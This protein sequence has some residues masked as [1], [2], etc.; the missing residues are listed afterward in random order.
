MLL[1]SSIYLSLFIYLSI[2]L[3]FSISLEVSNGKESDNMEKNWKIK[4]YW[5]LHSGLLCFSIFS[6]S[7]Y[8]LGEIWKDDKNLPL[9]IFLSFLL[10]LI[11]P[12]WLNLWW[13][14]TVPSIDNLPRWLQ[15]KPITPTTITQSNIYFPL[16]SFLVCLL[17][18]DPFLP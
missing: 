15:S 12:C 18:I 6:I 14:L 8:L 10:K 17:S 5:V 9:L 2:Y 7:I 4:L 16:F 3:S 1:C 13:N 11:H